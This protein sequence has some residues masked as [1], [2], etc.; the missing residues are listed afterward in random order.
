M[1]LDSSNIKVVIFTKE[2]SDIAKQKEMELINIF[3][4]QF[5]Q[6]N[7]KVTCKK[8]LEKKNGQ[9]EVLIK[10]AISMVKSTELEFIFGMTNLHILATGKKMKL[11]AMVFIVGMTVEHFMDSGL[12]TTCTDMESMYGL[13]SEN[14]KANM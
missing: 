8:V 6:A 12:K 5:I 3:K 7:G 9:M 13:T 1:E 2:N 10:D 14:M 11:Q 4:E